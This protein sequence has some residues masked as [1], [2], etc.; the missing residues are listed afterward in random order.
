[1]TIE[2]II[3]K[4]LGDEHVVRVEVEKDEGRYGDAILRVQIVFDETEGPISLDAMLDLPS[5]IRDALGDDD[6]VGFP[7]VSYV[8]QR[9]APTL[10]AAQ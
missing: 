4:C 8:D 3:R 7:V 5:R 9:E 2:E 6:T 10:H 1:M